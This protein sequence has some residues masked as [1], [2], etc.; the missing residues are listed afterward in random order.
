MISKL[1]NQGFKDQDRFIELSGLD[2]FTSR[3]VS[4]CDRKRMPVPDF[5]SVVQDRLS[6][7]QPGS[8]DSGRAARHVVEP[9]FVDEGD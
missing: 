7:C 1:R 6:R 5:D 4:Q 9:K 2:L 3:N 8:V